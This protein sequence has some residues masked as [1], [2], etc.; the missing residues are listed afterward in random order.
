M[1]KL[2][3]N[4]TDFLFG[5]PDKG[6][7][8]YNRRFHT[9]KCLNVPS[10]ILHFRGKQPIFARTNN[11]T[12]RQIRPL[13][14]LSLLLSFALQT[15]S[16]SAASKKTVPTETL[17]NQTWISDNGNGTFT[18][19][20]F[21]DEFSDP[22]LIRVGD[23][24]YLTGT[25]MHAMPGLPVLHSK[26]LVNWEL[27]TYACPRLDLGPAFRLEEG[28]DIY[29]Q[30]IWAPTMRYHKDTFYILTNV[31]GFGTQVFT[32]KN[33]AGPWTQHPLNASLHDLSVLFDDDGKI[34]AIW[35]YNEIR[36]V[37]LNADLTGTVP[38]TERV[39]IPANSGAGEGSHFYKINGKYYITLTNYD[40]LCY[41]VAARAD[42][43]EGPYEIALISAEEN[44]GYGTGWRMG[45]TTLR[46]PFDIKAPQPNFVGSV[47]QHQGGLVQTQTGEWWAF[48]MMDFNS[49][50]RTLTLAPVTW[51]KGWPYIGLPGNLTRA[52]RTWVKPN[53]G[54]SSTPKA[55]FERSDDFSGKLL[56]PI[57][58][59]NHAPV[60]DKW[61]LSKRPGSLRLKALPADDFWRAKNTLTQRAIGPES[62]ATTQLDVKGMKFGDVAGLGLLNLPYAWIGLIK[63]SD[64]LEI[65]QYDQQ[66]N[67]ITKVKTPVTTIWLRAH[68]NFENDKAE[69]SY[70][71]DG[72]NFV[73]LGME[74]IM[75]YQ[76]KTFQGIRFALFN[77]NMTE[78]EG[79]VVDF[80][81]FEVYEPRPRGLMRPIPVGKIIEL[82]NLGDNTVL[83][84]WRGFLR[85]VQPNSPFTA[86]SATQFRVI[87]RG[88][89][90]IAL[91]SVVDGGFVSVLGLGLM[92]EVRILPKDA[93]AAS[94]FQW[95][96]MLRDDLMLM[97]LLNHRYLFADANAGS[98][99]S[100]DAVGT[101]PDR[102]DGACFSWKIVG[103]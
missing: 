6:P 21:Y 16:S 64:G 31:N 88:N 66:D 72:K 22:D 76:L 59:W 103:E 14:F 9:S 71:L 28:K 55:V 17:R 49:V 42:K 75:V 29:G 13:L 60:E 1:P 77:Y 52:P 81:F 83:A 10:N 24:Y 2:S 3:Y 8:M 65:R 97:S 91:Q 50:G 48:T 73:L 19:P 82:T 93:G 78:K 99:C 79:G 74:C 33:P 54:F 38:S 35:G 12:M 41:Q 18:N 40:P 4:L 100:A 95:E 61:S 20:L 85:P 30:G 56:N 7:V 86:R 80:N 68:C 23:D 101:R 47:T 92:S 27:L 43:P 25:T 70:S 57:W 84:N 58:Q 51:E 5:V 34:Y 32:A 36:Q 39:I 37:E 45:R 11:C 63:K 94:T 15:T 62:Y 44:Y 69:F 67:C 102:K 98:L 90:R 26:D 89:G 87:D 46:V 96:D 53:T